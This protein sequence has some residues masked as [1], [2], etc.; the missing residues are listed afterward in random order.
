MNRNFSLENVESDDDTKNVIVSTIK[1]EYE[2]YNSESF[3]N[4]VVSDVNS[5]CGTSEVC[6]KQEAP[7]SNEIH[8][9]ENFE[10]RGNY[11]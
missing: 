11:N 7:T 5:R 10:L 6:V 3:T 1:V 8:T 2:N 9:Q 4:A